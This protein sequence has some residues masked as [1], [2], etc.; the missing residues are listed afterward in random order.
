MIWIQDLFFSPR[1]FVAWSLPVLLFILSYFFPVFFSVA[2]S[3]TILCV[4]L[5]L[6]DHILLFMGRESMQ[7]S[8]QTE[9][10]WSLAEENEVNLHLISA[11]TRPTSVVVIDELPVQFQARDFQRSTTIEPQGSNTIRYSLKPLSRGQY[12]FGKLHLYV[13]TKLGLLQRRFSISIPQTVKV[14]PSFLHLKRFQLKAIGEKQSSGLRVLRRGHSN[15][16]D[17]IKEY[18]R[19]D[20]VRTVNWKASAR[21][22]QF[23]IN[24][25]MDEK[26]QQVYCVIDKG[27]LMKLPFDNLS[28]LDYSINA[29]LMFSYVVIQKEDKIGLLTFAEKVDE[30]IHPSR[31]K[32]Q[33]N[34]IMEALYKLDTGFKESDFAGL[35]Q[36]ISRRAGQRSLLI[37]FTHF[38]SFIGFE[39]QLPYLRA[40]NRK[41]LLCLVMFENTGV[42]AL[43][44][45]GDDSLESI[46]TATIAEKFLYEKKMIVKE[47]R[48]HGIR[49]VYTNPSAVTVDAV[50]AYL[51]LKAGQII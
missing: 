7:G 49:V 20:D 40:L 18:N 24:A 2:V 13:S 14:Y 15:E 8:R 51:E 1:F 34:S 47:L 31:S 39:R 16:F 10:R 33:F 30:C 23:M 50:N 3:V 21:R 48:K 28:L 41:H 46:Y 22:N 38:E 36:W 29:A 44:E 6:L 42:K 25:F 5:T 27:R 17:H 12:H 26:S 35:Y 4:C 19:G 32:K 43:Q 11:Y 9:D 45:R 37:L